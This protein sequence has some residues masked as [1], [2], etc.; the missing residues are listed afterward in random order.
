MDSVGVHSYLKVVQS[1]QI[2]PLKKG[3]LET[4]TVGQFQIIIFHDVIRGREQYLIDQHG[5]AQSQGGTSGNSI[6][7][8]AKNNPKASQYELAR[9]EEFD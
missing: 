8:Y 4:A 3:H 1:Q 2:L 6:R 9:M 7:G 5:G